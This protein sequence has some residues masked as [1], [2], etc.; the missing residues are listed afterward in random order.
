MDLEDFRFTPYVA[1]KVYNRYDV[2]W[3]DG[4]DTIV[5]TKTVTERK[6]V[7][8]PEEKETP[9]EMKK[10]ARKPPKDGPCKRCG[11]NKPLNRLFLCYVCWVKVENEKSG[12]KEGQNHPATC[13]C[14]VECAA[15]RKDFGN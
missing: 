13:G 8:V 2:V 15:E 7:D 12:W 14:D 11:E 1:L 3:Y 9:E 4:S 6:L 10:R 5:E